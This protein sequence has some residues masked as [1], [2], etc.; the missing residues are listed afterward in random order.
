VDVYSGLTWLRPAPDDFRV[1]CRALASAPEPDT[2][3]IRQLANYALDGNQLKQLASVIEKWHSERREFA[4]LTPFKLGLVSNSTAKSF[5]PALIV[6]AAR[7]GILLELVEADYGQTITE[8]VDPASRINAAKTDAVLVALDV[9]GVPLRHGSYDATH[10]EAVVDKALRFT[11]EIREGFRRHG[12][13]LSIVQTLAS[14]PQTLF[15]NFERNVP[16][17][18]RALVCAYNAGLVE[19]VR[20][21]ND[22]LFDVAALAET[23]GLA[24]W[25]SPTQWNMAKFAFASTFVPLYADHVGRILGA[26]RGKSRKCLILD[27]DNTLW[28]G[29]V[30]D[31]GLEGIVLGQGDPTGEAH[32]ELQQAALALRERG[33]VLAVSSKND[34]NVAR[35]PFSHHPE[36]LLNEH[37]FAVFQANWN[38]KATNIAA[39][40][41][42][43]NLGVDAMV[44]LDDNPAERKLVRDMLPEVAVPEL[45][46]DP[47]LYS[48]TLLAAGYFEAVAYSEEDRKRADFYQE[49]ARR[50]TLQGMAGDI[51]SYLESL[52]MTIDFRPFD[53]GGRARIAQLVN[54]SNQFNLTTR[55]YTESDIESMAA[56]PSLFTLQARLSDTFGDNGMISVIVCRPVSATEWEIDT[57]LMSCRVLSRGVEKMVLREITLHARS[58][59]VNKLIG[60]FYP[61]QRNEMVTDHYEK[62]GFALVER[63][64]DGFS[65]W[66]LSTDAEIPAGPMKVERRGFN[67]ALA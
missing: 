20:Q 7:H 13:A 4:G 42:E 10:A 65:K 44:F 43:L 6:S 64:P 58:R 27:L 67:L 28:G 60:V 21:T 2:R 63:Q 47:A 36:M 48:R 39:I 50:A 49:K 33:I 30:G 26:L 66:E 45:P 29:I 57:W 40:A 37:H 17:S 53:A 35:A 62:L 32:L 11:N 46:D 19:S 15:G 16:G 12:G 61:T 52:D 18:L 25:H 8:A 54:K 24:R 59:G 1:R 55:R 5:S 31:D 38:D 3:A 23:V 41:K 14:D 56:D 51:E 34:D 22:V 9:R